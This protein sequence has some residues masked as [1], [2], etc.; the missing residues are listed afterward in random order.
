MGTEQELYSTEYEKTFRQEEENLYEALFK[1]SGKKLRY[2]FN[3][4]YNA[5]SEKLSA[6]TGKSNDAENSFTIDI[7][8]DEL[9]KGFENKGKEYDLEPVTS[10]LND[11]L[12]KLRKKYPSAAN[13]WSRK[14]IAEFLGNYFGLKNFI[15]KCEKVHGRDF[16]SADDLLEALSAEE[17]EEGIGIVNK[18]YPVF[19]TGGENK[20]Q[21]VQLIY[22]LHKAKLLNNGEGE[23]TKIVTQLAEMLN[24]DLGKGWQKNHSDS[25]HRNSY[26]YKP[27]IFEQI[28]SAY[29]SYFEQ[30]IKKR[31]ENQ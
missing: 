21:F 11:H 9:A 17:N 18:T 10:F 25:I 5:L 26:G 1:N 2:K 19:W 23:I 16:E 22:G 31:K 20:T 13:D 8:L 27:T 30:Q 15:K 6:L 3:E 28:S 7:F 24:V 4:Y 14:K 29:L 12:E